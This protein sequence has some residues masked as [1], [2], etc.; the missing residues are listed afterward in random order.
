MSNQ[1]TPKK[2]KQKHPTL[3]SKSLLR[4]AVAFYGRRYFRKNVRL[5]ADDALKSIKPPY[6]VVANH[7]GWADVGGLIMQAYPNCINFVIS[8]TQIVK[9]PKLIYKMGILPKKQFAPSTSLIRDIKYVLDNNR[10]VAIYPEAKLSVVGTP[11]IIKPNIAKL[12]KLL[13]YPLVTVRFDGS[14]LHKPRWASN[15]RFVPLKMTA[16]LAVS[17]EDVSALS[18]EQIHNVIVGDL[19]FDDYAYQ[20]ENKIKIDVPRLVEGLE[21]VLYKCPVCGEEFAMTAKGNVLSCAKCGSSVTQ[22]EYG[23][24]VGGKFDKVTNWYEWQRAS[25][26]CE[27]A[28]P[29][30][31][32]TARFRAE[33]LVKSKYVDMGDATITHNAQGL[34]AAFANQT[35]FFKAGAFYTLSFN[36]DYLYLPASD[37]V[38]RFK[39]LEKVGCTTKFNLSVEEQTKMLDI[40]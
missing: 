36:N 19:A 15:K 22:D 14:Y 33:K 40:S 27:L 28:N 25:V 11:N 24:I 6:I 12:V 16:R 9:W 26:A 21:N 4:L 1:Q 8:E 29:D 10:I 39:R 38:Y 35:L 31:C 5:V 13:K 2:F 23:S 18:V 20:L 34:T 37:A 17:K 30:Y 3:A 32:L 7:A